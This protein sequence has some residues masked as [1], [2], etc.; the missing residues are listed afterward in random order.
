MSKGGEFVPG[1]AVPVIQLPAVA[2]TGSALPVDAGARAHALDISV[3]C[4][5]TA[6]AGSGKTE[7]LTQRMLGLLAVVDEPEE[8]LA[9]TFTRKAAAEM[10][11]RLL[12]ALAL[13]M[14]A[15][16]PEALHRRATWQLARAALARDSARNW[17]LLHNPAR[18]RLQTIDSFC[19]S[20]ASEQPVLSLLGAA[21]Q[22]VDDPQRLYKQAVGEMLATLGEPGSDDRALRRLLAYYRGDV[23]GL[24][25]MLAAML[26]GRDQWLASMVDLTR[27]AQ[28]GRDS[29]AELAQ[30][31]EKW[32]AELLA[33]ARQQLQ[34]YAAELVA[35]AGFA[36]S[37][38][39]DNPALANSSPIAKLAGLQALPE[40]TIAALPQ[41]RALLAL[42]LT[43]KSG[44][45]RTIDKR[46]GFPID[47][48][49]PAEMRTR[50]AAN[51]QHLL[52]ICAEIAAD[53]ETLAAL[54]SLSNLP[55]SGYGQAQDELLAAM[56]HCL[57]QLYAHLQLVFAEQ[58]R[59]DHS[60]I[61]AAALRVLGANQPQAG[62]A[63]YDP[64]T[65]V[66]VGTAYA[67]HRRLR[68]ILVDEYQDTSISQYRLLCALSGEWAQLNATQNEP[69][70]TLF[71]V[72]D[73]M[74]SIYAFRAARV[75]LFLQARRGA[76]GDLPLQRI[77]L[78][79]NFRSSARLVDWFNRYLGA[80]FPQRE[81]SA[82][83]AV[84]FSRAVAV[85]P[86]G[87]AEA[88]PVPAAVAGTATAAAGAATAAAGP[89]AFYAC[90]GEDADVLEAHK[91]LE[92]V[93][94][95]LAVRPHASIAILVRVR[96]HLQKIL[97]VL[98][99]AG[100]EVQNSGIDALSE[101][102]E[103]ADC[104]ALT[105][106]LL[107]VNDDIAWW[108]L[109]RAPWCGLPLAEL[110]VLR[111]HLDSCAQCEALPQLLVSAC[112]C[113]SFCPHMQ[114]LLADDA[115]ARV[116]RL[117]N[118]VGDAWR[119]RQRAG[120]RDSVEQ[121]WHALGGKALMALAAEPDAAAVVAQ[122]FTEL[123]Q[124][125]AECRHRGEILHGE[126]LQQRM[127][128]LR[129]EQASLS[130]GGVHAMT[131][132]KA[133]GLEFDTVI[134][135]GLAGLP[136]SEDSALLEFG[137][138]VFADG[139]S[140]VLL[141]PKTLGDEE[142]P[143][144]SESIGALPDASTKAA[145]DGKHKKA[146]GIYEF[147]RSEKKLQGDYE[148]TR[149]LYVAATRARSR[150]LLTATM[151]CAVGHVG[152]VDAASL[153]P[154]PQR[155]LLAKL[156][157]ALREQAQLVVSTASAAQT[158]VV[159]QPYYRPLKRFSSAALFARPH[160]LDDERPTA[161]APTGDAPLAGFAVEQA[162]M[163]LAT[164]EFPA[165]GVNEAEMNT[166]R[167]ILYAQPRWMQAV[168]SCVHELLQ[169]AV[170]QGPGHCKGLDPGAQ[171]GHWRERL[172]QLGVTPD[173]ME[174][175]V[176]RLQRAVRGVTQAGEGRKLLQ[177]AAQGAACEWELW[178]RD[179]DGVR[180][181]ARMDLTFIDPEGRRWLV[182]Y[183]IAEP[184]AGEAVADFLQQQAGHYR[185][186]VLRYRALLA[187]FD[188]CAPQEIVAALYYPLLDRLLPISG[189]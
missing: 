114:G 144:W 55:S 137:E 151:R 62:G 49:W 93:Q 26:Q 9:I 12:G 41:W 82:R 129:A 127:D 169:L 149:L 29:A 1:D 111:D 101:R 106:A 39:R 83:G 157:P 46:Q 19:Y 138:R 139:S 182:D 71:I 118:I 89:V 168:G 81:D 180:H 61:T 160:W 136:R 90:V 183:K 70:R 174:A 60:E 85:A 175:A 23:Q 159:D 152:E 173:C 58:R 184:A 167:A 181:R 113:G 76:L 50:S 162:G 21:L 43:G 80:A 37:V 74:Q 189:V 54:Q 153:Q 134:L 98:R 165:A 92:L 140:G 31:L 170:E 30:C 87:T 141:Y 131:M 88:E 45:R 163:P 86:P 94:R 84:T 8:I 44:P 132:H 34:R 102:E 51:K 107:S 47:K 154:P 99:A 108:A 145:G 187:S 186:Q 171:D 16:A 65:T 142:Y 146:R 78:V 18:L 48:S 100:I 117:A 15:E 42:L 177:R 105:R 125:D 161:A 77:D 28:A 20:V 72:G 13:G 7:L 32:I 185:D 126:L 119:L 66:P 156:W 172:R 24:S 133:K 59:C 178:Y 112:E 158:G 147:L 14:Q 4:V 63:Q 35:I 109:L 25:G 150:L 155:S 130:K 123:E 11:E 52:Q 143:A 91:V 64:A 128:M 36:G 56:A 103:V 2:A 104:L 135:P 68:H 95:E 73:A 97:P 188:H 79:Q 5:V 110:Q 115:A 148:S 121:C 17:Q 124:F 96:G 3:S 6:P 176:Q 33:H 179:A 40:N 69:A 22:P 53:E 120:L 164:A 57:V 166:A 10:R 38:L 122:Y 27:A 67:W 75:Q 116:L